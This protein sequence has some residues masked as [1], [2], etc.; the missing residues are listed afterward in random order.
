VYLQL[1]LERI[2]NALSSRYLSGEP[3]NYDQ[4][5]RLQVLT[6]S[7]QGI[8]AGILM[9]FPW[10]A[11]S[12]YLKRYTTLVHL[13]NEN[14]LQIRTV[15]TKLQ[16][17]ELRAGLLV[18]AVTLL[19]ATWSTLLPK[20][21]GQGLVNAAQPG[22]SKL[23]WAVARSSMLNILAFGLPIYAAMK[24]GAVIVAMALLLSSA[25]GVPS[26]I[27]D[28]C[29]IR[30]TWKSLKQKKFS[31][32]VLSILVILNA[33]GLDA[34]VDANSW[35]GYL[36][37]FASI[38]VLPPSF[39]T[40]TRN[41]QIGA[42]VVGSATSLSGQQALAL[43]TSSVVLSP[44]STF[45]TIVFGILLL[46]VTVLVTLFDGEITFNMVDL[47][48]SAATATC[49]AVPLIFSAPSRL[50]VRPKIGLAAALI[51]TCL[52][53]ALPHP[54]SYRLT[55]V[56]WIS[57]ATLSF[58][59]A[60]LDGTRSRT[61]HVHRSHNHSERELSIVT[62]YLIRLGESYPLLYS[63]LKE[64]DSRRIFYF[65]WYVYRSCSVSTQK[66]MRK[67]QLCLYAR[68]TFVWLHHWITRPSQ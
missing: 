3:G 62:R 57:V 29:N 36:A 55:Y 61:T 37:L 5:L 25:S 67:P 53:S 40:A 41:S 59:A 52:F 6:S 49:F 2:S 48:L 8:L 14:W 11:L 1:A 32:S 47:M 46:S 54:E 30:V 34:A 50:A 66:L 45:F 19:V 35:Q 65:M 7:S 16:G 27:N 17:A 15:Q 21:S 33:L 64:D 60:R 10:V 23:S 44:P 28:G 24:T 43:G 13:D 4:V 26:L 12:W 18:S 51:F 56:V 68:A 63:I 20:Q 58:M 22:V 31:L 42:K 39:L 9:A 38:F